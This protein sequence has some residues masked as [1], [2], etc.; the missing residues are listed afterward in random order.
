MRWNTKKEPPCQEVL[1]INNLDYEGWRDAVFLYF[2][3]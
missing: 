1:H 3:K 2:G